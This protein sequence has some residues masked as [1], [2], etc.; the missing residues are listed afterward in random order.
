[1]G[2]YYPDISPK[3]FNILLTLAKQHEDYFT[4]GDCP[5]NEAVALKELGFEEDFFMA[6]HIL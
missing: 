5:Y 3:E 1:M 6:D 4:S 2:Y